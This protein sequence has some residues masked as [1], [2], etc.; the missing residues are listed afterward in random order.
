MPLRQKIAKLLEETVTI[1]STNDYAKLSG[2]EFAKVF[3]ELFP[4]TSRNGTP[5]RSDALNVDRQFMLFNKKYKYGRALIIAAT[6]K[7]IVEQALNNF[8]YC[9]SAINLILSFNLS[10]LAD[11]CANYTASAESNPFAP[12]T[13]S[14]TSDTQQEHNLDIYD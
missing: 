9:K 3:V 4:N 6:T 13:V 8:A 5:F 11:L 7:Y 12:T 1:T 2:I 14:T 10:T